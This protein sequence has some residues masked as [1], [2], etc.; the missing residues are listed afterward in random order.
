MQVTK[1][2]TQLKILAQAKLR[3]QAGDCQGAL[4][5]L[6]EPRDEFKRVPAAWDAMIG[7]CWLRLGDGLAAATFLTGARDE[8]GDRMPVEQRRDLGAALFLAGRMEAAGREFSMVAASGAGVARPA[9]RAAIEAYSNRLSDDLDRGPPTPYRVIAQA[10]ALSDAKDFPAARNLLMAALELHGREWSP[11]PAAFDAVLGRILLRC[12]E[13]EAA[14]EHLTRARDASGDDAPAG[15]RQTLGTALFD[16]GRVAE[17]GR[18]LDLAVRAGAV[19][20]RVEL[21]IST[22]AYRAQAG[23]AERLDTRFARNLTLVDPD[24]HLAYVSV[25]K[26]A[27]SLLKA[28]FVLSSRHRDAYIASGDNI[29]VFCTGLSMGA[30]APEVASDPAYFRFTVLREPMRRI[31]SAYLDKIVDGRQETDHYMRLQVAR[32][33]R[34]AQAALGLTDDPDRSITFE[35]FVRYLATAE[36]VACDLHWMPQA[37]LVGTDLGRYEHVGRVEHLADTLDLL[38]SRFGYV[39]PADGDPNLD[40]HDPHA[41]RFSESAALPAPH[42]AVPAALAALPDGLPMPELFLTRELTD[43]LTRRY[44]TDVALYASLN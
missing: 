33:V 4:D 38:A 24:R 36:D 11:L 6:L 14:I 44:A 42:R 20:H 19:L 2:E 21:V 28:G 25:P 18:E 8:Y 32:T 22:N 12:G 7:R 3:L 30:T 29:H 23:N 16:V 10:E 27:C 17:A 40:V 31:L 5:L 39:G 43:L 15:M 13:R 35:E 9:Y 26:N 1:E 37:Q 34:A 41:A